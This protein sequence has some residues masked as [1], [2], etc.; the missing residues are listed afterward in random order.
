VPSA[1]D[2]ALKSRWRTELARHRSVAAGVA[3]AA[4]DDLDT[5]DE[6]GIEDF[7]AAAAPTIAAIRK[8]TATMTAG[9]LGKLTATPM[10]AMTDDELGL[11]DDWY[12]QPFMTHW[13]ALAAGIAFEV[14]VERGRSRAEQV[15][16]DGV[17]SA[18]RDTAKVVDAN[19]ERSFSWERTPDPDACPWCTE[20]AGQLYNTAETADFGHDRCACDVTPAT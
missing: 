9:F 19:T 15:G 10:V 20:V 12:R 5:Y 13:A 11:P 14:A 7:E 4:W 1:R 18:A 3:A 16:T 17:T 2:A 6:D 8:R